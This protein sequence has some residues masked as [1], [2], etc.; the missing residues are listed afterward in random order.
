MEDSLDLL[1][2]REGTLELGGWEI[3]CHHLNN[4]KRLITQKSFAG[5]IGMK[6]NNEAPGSDLYC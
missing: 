6:K 1:A 2:V 4:G 5:V 3:I